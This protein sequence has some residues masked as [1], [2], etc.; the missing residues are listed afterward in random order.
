MS[1]TYTDNCFA[2]GNVGQT[3]L[4]HMEENFAALK[5]S[6][7]GTTTPSNTVAGMLWLDTTANILKVRNKANNA[8]LSV[9]DIANNKPVITNLSAE[10][11]LA[12]MAAAC[13]NAAAGT[14]SLRTLSTTATTA[15][16]GNDSRL[17]NTRTPTDLSVTEGKIGAGAVTEGKIGA[18]AVAQGKLKTSLGSVSGQGN[19]TL[20]GG[21]YGFYPQLKVASSGKVSIA[22]GLGSASYVTNIWLP[23]AA[24]TPYAQQR[25]VTS[26]GEVFWIFLLRDKVS[27]EIIG[28]YEAPD[29]PCF[30]NGGKPLLVPH[31]FPDFNPDKQEIIVI[32][33]SDEDVFN[34]EDAC[35]VEDETKPDRDMLEVITEDYEIDEDLQT[36]WIRKEITVGLPR[37]LDWRRS[38]GESVTPVKKLIPQMEYITTRKLWKRK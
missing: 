31:P 25:Y 19:R 36:P 24:G 2:P 8:W 30:G 10:I 5:S 15:C 22:D 34:M 28:M 14:A 18:S 37:G 13:R 7:S 20:P 38:I 11:T 4:G 12:M 27:K 21:E 23:E 17:S 32:N 35:I 29:H 3:D 26:S 33:P 6:F 9:W 1:Q 16:A